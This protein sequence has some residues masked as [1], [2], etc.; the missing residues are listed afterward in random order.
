M[1]M[2]PSSW[3]N[4]QVNGSDSCASG[5]SFFAS[6]FNNSPVMMGVVEM[7][8]TTTTARRANSPTSTFRYDGSVSG[9]RT[10]DMGGAGELLFVQANAATAR[11]FDKELCNFVGRTYVLL[12]LHIP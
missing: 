4:A 11:F 2:P 8:L 10:E 1:L 9:P 5:E 7:L 3:T 12:V 6:F